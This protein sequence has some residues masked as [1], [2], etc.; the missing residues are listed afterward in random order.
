[1]S[2]LAIARALWALDAFPRF[3]ALQSDRP[4]TERAPMPTEQL[5]AGRN[6]KEE[7]STHGRR[8]DKATDPMSITIQGVNGEPSMACALN[9]GF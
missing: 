7:G 4:A 5:D 9:A 6:L 2:E 3:G 8:L 1:M